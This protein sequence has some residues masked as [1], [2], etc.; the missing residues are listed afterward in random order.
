MAACSI[1]TSTCSEATRCRS[2]ARPS[3]RFSR[4]RNPATFHDATRRDLAGS[5]SAPPLRRRGVASMGTTL[6]AA[7][8]EEEE[9]GG[10]E[11][12]AAAG[13]VGRAAGPA[14]AAASPASLRMR[15]MRSAFLPDT[16]RPSSR[17]RCLSATTVRPASSSSLAECSIAGSTSRERWRDIGSGSRTAS[18]GRAS[19]IFATR[20]ASRAR[21]WRRPPRGRFQ[22]TTHIQYQSRV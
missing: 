5:G 18:K 8:V 19:I 14:P 22:R 11:G 16:G 12:A 1:T 7:V 9:G 13:S 17:R 2:V 3:S 21:C 20:R 15:A 10:E 6:L 4:P